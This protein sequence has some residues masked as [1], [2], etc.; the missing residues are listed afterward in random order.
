M[1]M[2]DI[3]QDLLSSQHQCESIER[4]ANAKKRKVAKETGDRI[5]ARGEREFTNETIFDEGVLEKY[6]PFLRLR[7]WPYETRGLSRYLEKVVLQEVRKS[8]PDV[9]MDDSRRM[10]VFMRLAG[11]RD[12]YP[13]L[14]RFAPHVEQGQVVCGIFIP[15][16]QLKDGEEYDPDD[17]R[18]EITYLNTFRIVKTRW[19]FTVTHNQKFSSDQ[20]LTFLEALKH[21]DPLYEDSIRGKTV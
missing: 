6:L 12:A 2:T 15:S 16:E 5:L 18:K 4:E 20:D 17:Y 1:D 9:D 21:I 10:L 19:G 8:T 11:L 3:N 7:S 14:Q 13:F